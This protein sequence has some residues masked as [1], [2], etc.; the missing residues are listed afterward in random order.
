MGTE[1][2]ISTDPHVQS[3]HI[4]E[5]LNQL[6]GHLRKTV[7]RVTDARFQAILETS[8][9][10]LIG[11]GTVYEHFDT[12]KEAAFPRRRRVQSEEL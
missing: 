9:E 8:A 3:E 5:Q 2:E 10:V 11:L 4:Q 6:V 12:G 1:V 7:G